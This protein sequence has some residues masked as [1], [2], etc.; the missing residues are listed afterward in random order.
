MTAM[1]LAAVALG[2]VFFGLSMVHADDCTPQ[3]EPHFTVVLPKV[4]NP[5]NP[6]GW[7]L[8]PV[9]G[10][11][12]NQVGP[13]DTI[14]VPNGR[15]I[16][17]LIVSGYTNN[18]YLDQLMVYDFV[19]HLMDQ[20][21]YVHYAWWNNLLAPY[22]ERPL[23]HP[24]SHPGTASDITSFT[25][26][27]AAE[28]KA[29]PGENHQ[30]LADAKRFLSAIRAH[31]PEAVIVLV[32]HS[33]GGH[34]VAQLANETN[35]LIDLVAPIDPVW[36]RTYPWVGPA[37]QDTPHYNWT[38]YRATS[39]DF[40]GYRSMEWKADPPFGGE[41]VPFGPWRQ[42]YSDAATDSTV[43]C[44]GMVHIHG[45]SHMTFGSNIINLYH[46]WQ[47]EA[48]FPFDFAAARLFNSGFPYPSGGQH[49]I[50]RSGGGRLAAC[51]TARKLVLPELQRCGLARRRA[52]RDH[53]RARAGSAQTA[54]L[55]RQNK[56]RVRQWM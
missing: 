30:F 22:M 8:P 55:P 32:G 21:A 56:S 31:N 12:N 50:R 29:V 35:V 40:K 2:C 25:T 15:P 34:S 23:H 13:S 36:S 39:E 3:V 17:A 49:T 14:A 20:G 47:H 27:A 42:R 51:R 38:R 6:N 45:A 18:A 48:K 26:P 33:M 53:R 52:R 5:P 4:T 44:G 7:N 10:P 28:N 46:R 54:W 43:P 37:F 9:W 16:Y 19:R 41:C 11:I 24:Q 1:K